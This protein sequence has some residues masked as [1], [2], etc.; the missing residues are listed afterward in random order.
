[1]QTYDYVIVGAG[2]AGCVLANRLSADPKIKVLLIE[3]G[4]SHDSLRI[5]TPGLVGLLWRSRYDWTYF[6]TPQ[7][8]LDGRKMHWPRGKGLGGSSS[9]NYMI[10]MRGHRANYD[11]WRDLGNQGWG[12][13]DVLPYFKRSENNVR[14]ADAFHGAGG[15]LEVSDTVVNPMS[16]LLVEATK[17]ALSVAS[18]EDFNGAQQEGAG[19]FQATIHRGKCC[20]SA[21][22]F[23]DSARSRPN[24][25]IETQALVTGL[26]FEKKRAVSVRFLKGK[27]SREVRAT[28]EIILSAGAIGSPHLLKLSGVGPADELRRNGIAVVHDAQGVGRNLQDHVMVPVAVEDRGKLTGNI[29]P[30]NL[31]RWLAEHAF[32]GTGPM[33]SNAAESGAFVRTSPSEKL[34]DIQMHYLP[35]ASDQINYDQSAF[36]PKGH[37]FVL[38]PTLLYPKSRGEITLAGPDAAMAPRIDPRYFEDDADLRALI[39]GVR[40]AQQVIRSTQLDPYRGRALSPLVAAED[41][42]TLRTEIK[43]R[44]NT[45]FHPV[46]TCAMGQ[47]GE[48]VV[49]A[50]LKVHGLEGLRVV[51]ASIMPTIVGGNTNA[52][53]IMIAEKAADLIL[54][55]AS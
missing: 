48:S 7:R 10:Y 38:I 36:M 13:E 35:V 5:S 14:G 47:G 37:A 41:E 30:H 2:S 23:V 31:L 15:P 27:Q 46:G 40:M 26:G 25:T 21:V 11:H 6:T 51:D 53:T 33:A 12:Y 8:Q 28:H 3:A 49:D 42:A 17:D 54:E 43:R 52:P 1:M 45:L 44:C 50:S 39:A 16:D 4:G 19:R 22:A 55:R 29:Q 20:S 18:N 34:P 24:L 9:I 32:K